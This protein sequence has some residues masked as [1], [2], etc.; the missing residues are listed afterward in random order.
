MVLVLLGKINLMELTTWHL[1]MRISK[2]IFYDPGNPAEEAEDYT[3]E[4]QAEAELTELHCG[5]SN[6]P[7]CVN[8]KQYLIRCG[9]D[10]KRSQS[11]CK[12]VLIVLTVCT[13]SFCLQKSVR[14]R[15]SD[16]NHFQRS[17]VL[18]PIFSASGNKLHLLSYNYL[19]YFSFTGK[20]F[21]N[22]T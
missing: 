4:N 19:S 21:F 18:G 22:F 17:S 6:I 16:H 8:C 5:D 1:A 10:N 13:K 14:T 7:V 15:Q 20:Y 3:E 2:A 9:N 12:Y 11:L